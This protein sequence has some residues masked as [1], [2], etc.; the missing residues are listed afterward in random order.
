MSKLTAVLIVVASASCLGAT[1]EATANRTI[2][3]DPQKVPYFK[4]EGVYGIWQRIPGYQEAYRTWYEIRRATAGVNN[5]IVN[6]DQ[7]FASI[8]SARTMNLPLPLAVNV[9]DL[10]PYLAQPL[11]ETL[12]ATDP[13]VSVAVQDQRDRELIAAIN[14]L[15]QSIE[16]LAGVVSLVMVAMERGQI[17]PKPNA[18]AAPIELPVEPITPDA[19]V[20]PVESIEPSEDEAEVVVVSQV[21]DGVAVHKQASINWLS[22]LLLLGL[23]ALMI[24]AAVATRRQFM[25]REKYY[26]EHSSFAATQQAEEETRRLEAELQS[27]QL[28]LQKVTAEAEIL[29]DQVVFSDQFLAVYGG[30]VILQ[31]LKLDENYP[32]PKQVTVV[33]IDGK[34]HMPCGTSVNMPN[35]RNH[36]YTKEKGVRCE[37][38]AEAVK[39]LA[40]KS[41]DPEPVAA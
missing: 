5:H 18:V 40:Q 22:W 20:V 38:C 12:V 3:I 1:V 17:G 32:D 28:E 24:V 4:T 30:R 31:T 8:P 26:Q 19:D 36:L 21:D 27:T 23:I 6:S 14:S 41:A 10:E 13:I 15:N 2:T 34:A 11:T 39:S 9:Q 35:A 25:R 29:G 16:Q 7:S 33:V 37:A